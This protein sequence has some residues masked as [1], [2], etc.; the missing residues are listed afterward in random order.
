MITNEKEWVD[1]RSKLKREKLQLEHQVDIEKTKLENEK[2]KFQQQ[3]DLM[4][5]EKVI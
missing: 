5:K 2:K 1:E 4:Q 3:S